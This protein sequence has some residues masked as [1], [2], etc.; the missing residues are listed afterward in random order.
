M[1]I[2]ILIIALLILNGHRPK[3]NYSV[4][5]YTLKNLPANTPDKKA[6]E[7]DITKE[8]LPEMP[9]I[10]DDG[11]RLFDT[12]SFEI[13]FSKEAAEKI[14]KLQPELAVGIPFVLTVDREPV[15]TGYFVNRLSSHGCAAY[16]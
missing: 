13:T 16:I 9:F 10:I 1:R 5:I 11:I 7:F 15:L 4:E 14:G 3:I 2:F 6:V 12:T 8:E